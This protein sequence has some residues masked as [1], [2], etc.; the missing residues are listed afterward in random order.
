[1]KANMKQAE[2]EFRITQNKQ[3]FVKQKKI[4]DELQAQ[5]EKTIQFL[6]REQLNREA[7][8]AAIDKYEEAED[9]QQK[10]HDDEIASIIANTVEVAEVV[11]NSAESNPEDDTGIEG[12]GK[13]DFIPPFEQDA[14]FPDNTEEGSDEDAV[15]KVQGRKRAISGSIEGDD[16]DLSQSHADV[17]DTNALL[18][19]LMKERR[20]A[21]SPRG[22]RGEDQE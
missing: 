20:G 2:A 16:P 17:I 5:K 8:Q 21:K 12:A 1:M 15:M 6:K 14:V 18:Q 13:N 3:A 10:Q 4:A 22:N 9:R 19:A 7:W 11:G